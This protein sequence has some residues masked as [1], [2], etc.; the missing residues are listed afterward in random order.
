MPSSYSEEFATKFLRFSLGNI[1]KIIELMNI[2]TYVVLENRSRVHR[3]EMM[4]RAIFEFSNDGKKS[5]LAIQ[6]GRHYTEQSR[7]LKYFIQF[8]YSKFKHLVYNNLDWW[9]RNGF[10]ENS[11]IAIQ[12]KCAMNINTISKKFALFIDCNCQRT[13][14]PGGGPREDGTDAERFNNETQRTFYNGWKS[15][16]GLKHQTVDNAYGMTVDMYGPCS[17]RRND[18]ELFRRSNINDRLNTICHTIGTSN[19]SMFGD[20]AYNNDTNISSY[21]PNN[22]D[23][24]KAMKGVRVQIE[25]NYG[26]TASLFPLVAN[27]KKLQILKSRYI[28][29]VYVVA[30]ILRNIHSCL[31]GNQTMLYFNISL[32]D[33]MLHRYLTQT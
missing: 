10:L 25:W 30:T 13:C 14:R 18:L 17:L 11:A 29:H 21:M 16:H 3:E 20:S 9:I 19:Y 15:I 27:K 12:S 22:H 8:I 33:D 26:H 23:F 32:P 1:K 24:N 28:H 31:Y 2:P 5:F 4:I 7:C 6:F